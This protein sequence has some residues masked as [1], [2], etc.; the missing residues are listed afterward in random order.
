MMC[1]KIDGFPELFQRLGKDHANSLLK[2]VG[3]IFSK[4]ARQED[5]LCRVGLD[6]FVALLTT[7][8]LTGAVRMAERV[9]EMIAA[10]KLQHAGRDEH[11]TVSVGAVKWRP[12]TI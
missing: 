10:I 11:V 7:N 4:H 3:E 1:L 6:T 12:E 2:K 5:M 9:R 8:N